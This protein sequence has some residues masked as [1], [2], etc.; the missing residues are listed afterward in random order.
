MSDCGLPRTLLVR[1]LVGGPSRAPPADG[2]PGRSR[3]L[4]VHH[5]R[6]KKNYVRVNERVNCCGDVAGSRRATT[7]DYEGVVSRGT[8]RLGI[9]GV[10]DRWSDDHNDVGARA[11]L[12]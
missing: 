8:Y 2:W 1:W 10:G 4:P 11:K 5:H 7:D 12:I 9:D 6:T 3:W